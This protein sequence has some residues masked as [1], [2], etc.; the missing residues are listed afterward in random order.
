MMLRAA[1][2]GSWPAPWPLGRGRRWGDTAWTLAAL[3]QAWLGGG[4]EGRWPVWRWGA[5]IPTGPRP[6]ECPDLFEAQPP[7]P[8]VALLRH[9]SSGV[10]P[11]LR[12]ASESEFQAQCWTALLEGDALPWLA[13]G[14]VFLDRDTR[15]RWIPLIGAVDAEGTLHLPPF[16]DI[17]VPEPLR[18]LPPTWWEGL[19]G[20]M[21]GDGRMIP[22]GMPPPEFA[23]PG[24]QELLG[25]LALP[26]LPREVRK[27]LPAHSVQDLPGFG[28]VLEPG[29]RAWARAPGASPSALRELCP[30]SLALG[31]A[32]G[33]GLREF[34][35]GRPSPAGT[36]PEGWGPWLEGELAGNRPGEA[37]GS[38]GHPTWDRIRVRWGGNFPDSSS[39][40][41]PAPSGLHPC[42][43]PFHWMAVG[44]RAFLSDHD[45]AAA[46]ESFA[47]AHAHFIRLRSPF[48]ARRA[49]ANAAHAAL[50]GAR[51]GSLP[52]WMK[53][54]GPLESPAREFDEAMLELVQGR[55][56]R[57][58][59]IFRGILEDHPEHFPAWW[60]LAQRGL[61]AG[62]RSLV[63]ECLP[64]ITNP[65]ARTLAEAW[66][67][68]LSPGPPPGM[69]PEHALV[70]Q[71]HRTLR[72]LGP[73]EAFWEAW[74]ACPNHWLRLE[75][76]LLLLERLPGQRTPEHLL[77]LQDLAGRSGSTHHLE[78]LR[79]LWPAVLEPGPELDPHDLVRDWIR[80]REL[81]TW[82]RFGD[83]PTELAT[84]LR[85]PEALCARAEAE[86]HLAPMESGGR[87]WWGFPLHW[88]GAP[89]AT[90]LTELPAGQPVAP[91]L[92]LALLAPWLAR[93]SA[94]RPVEAQPRET[95]ILTDGSE[96]M[97]TLLAECARVAPTELPVL[98]LGPTGSGKELV[99]RELHRL[100][101]RLGPFVAVNCAAF[102]EGVLESE[103]FGH[104]KG[105]FTGA[106]RERRGAIESA[107]G[108]TLFLDE[109]A[110]LTPRLQSLFL[111]V[112]Q[113]RE[114][115]RVGSDRTHQVDVRFL[116]ATHKPLERL[117]EQEAFRQD[118]WYRLRG[119]VLQLPS[120]RERR[121]EL[122]YL[123]P[124]LVGAISA[125]L[126]R[127]TP[128][129]AP[130][131]GKALARL[132]WPGNMRELIHA[133]ERA[134]LRCGEGLLSP[135]HFPE[136][137]VPSVEEKGW[138]EATRDFQ[139]RFLL[140]ALR[141]H[142]FRVSECAEALGLARPA[143]YVAAR[144]LGIDL[145][146]EKPR[147]RK[148][149]AP[150][151]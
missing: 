32:P 18:S 118:L 131:L 9:G 50:F 92:D 141:Q 10:D 116:A 47:L 81:P 114:V 122:P 123:L 84:P 119:S 96:P 28:V 72:G 22:T 121:H 129:I 33:P 120:L 145:R 37:P 27:A 99:A 35:E 24:L 23:L 19:L 100:S 75:E 43:D 68:D 16:L 30:E 73:E 127:P 3:S 117:V 20:S 104:V 115:R 17:L 44:E 109:V 58:V 132:P 86:P 136:L 64:H 97:A 39:G 45:M 76:G 57:S 85:P 55:W 79:A 101:G 66:L 126:D 87:T 113:E 31:D 61:A 36:T 106:E 151:P 105:A 125:R 74:R 112:L 62:D 91:A 88:E 4:R 56:E 124:R 38:S 41:P 11:G 107:Q 78:R 95:G 71:L 6:A 80:R 49:A 14:S 69:D 94:V 135:A 46:L 128:P 34:L 146:A 98:L 1:W 7:R 48:W 147:V 134:L 138:V 140:D 137:R 82:I 25:P 90:V 12:G 60:G 2:L 93:L 51:L 29:L 89:V 111:R 144:R 42:A 102:A 150:L 54:Q 63:E 52:S 21:G 77:S 70:W 26:A 103:L 8:W 59:R 133:T 130:G 53:A 83:P 15:A 110:D 139:R 5:K 67:G 143:L 13:A 65:Y 40:Y 149:R 148:P 108:G 142:Q